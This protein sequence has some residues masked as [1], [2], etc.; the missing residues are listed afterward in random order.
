LTK[1]D[2]VNITYLFVQ[3]VKVCGALVGDV[4]L[5]AGLGLILLSPL[6][7]SVPVVTLVLILVIIVYKVGLLGCLFAI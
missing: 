6:N 1:S 2:R 3:E 4:T 5:R 7:F